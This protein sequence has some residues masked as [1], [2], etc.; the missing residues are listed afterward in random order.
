MF[1][2]GIVT[3]C[4]HDD[5]DVN[6]YI[7]S[8]IAHQHAFDSLWRRSMAE[9]M[10]LDH[11]WVRE[12]ETQLRR[13]IG[14]LEMAGLTDSVTMHIGAMSGPYDNTTATD[15]F[16]YRTTDS[17]EVFVTDTAVFRAY[18]RGA[19]ADSTAWSIAAVLREPSA[20]SDMFA[21]EAG[22]RRCADLAVTSATRRVYSA[23]LIEYSQDPYPACTPNTIAV[24]TG[25]GHRVFAAQTRIPADAIMDRQRM[26][27]IA[28]TLIDRL[29]DR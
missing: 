8:R 9:A 11:A 1:L 20:F 12:H 4:A 17:V 5:A 25:A 27:A 10:K 2:F 14:P 13:I 16:V 7:G 21:A 22:A 28:R 29:P 24:S 26:E 6:E 3:A 18:V 19:S 23:M 15:G